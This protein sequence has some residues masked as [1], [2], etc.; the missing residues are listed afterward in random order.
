M[1]RLRS[2]TWYHEGLGGGGEGRGENPGRKRGERVGKCRKAGE[3]GK[4]LRHITLVNA[5]EKR[6]SKKQTKKRWESGLKFGPPLPSP[7][8]PSCHL[9]VLGCTQVELI[10]SKNQ[11]IQNNLYGYW[12]GDNLFAIERWMGFSPL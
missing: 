7:C 5:I 12:P 10:A 4:N 3:K 6:Q 1:A 8:T 9:H 11:T 2:W